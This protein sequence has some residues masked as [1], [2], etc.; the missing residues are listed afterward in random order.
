MFT[1]IEE[2]MYVLYLLHIYI[3][4]S[5]Y[6]WV[7]S[8]HLIQFHPSTRCWA[9][10]LPPYCGSLV[11]PRSGRYQQS[12]QRMADKYAKFKHHQFIGGFVDE[13]TLVCFVARI[14]KDP[15]SHPF[16]SP[17]KQALLSSPPSARWLEDTGPLLGRLGP[18]GTTACKPTNCCE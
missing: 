11:A 13:N 4:I 5:Y 2:Y 9:S 7:T 17:L 16:E 15:P 18:R 8:Y 1:R 10:L 12:F 3:Y 14:S 6:T